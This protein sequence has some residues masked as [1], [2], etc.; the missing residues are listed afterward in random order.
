MKKIIQCGWGMRTSAQER[1][2]DEE[3]LSALGPIRAIYTDHKICSVNKSY[4]SSHILN[5]HFLGAAVCVR[6]VLVGQ[7]RS[8]RVRPS[9]TKTKQS[10]LSGPGKSKLVKPSQTAYVKESGQVKPSQ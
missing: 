9:Q 3:S 5:S 10:D 4:N 6:R 8:G 7:D 1:A 2:L